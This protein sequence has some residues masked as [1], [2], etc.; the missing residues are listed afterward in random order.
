MIPKFL[1]LALRVFKRQVPSN[2][3]VHVLLY[4]L[5]DFP[6]EPRSLGL[7]EGSET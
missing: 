7:T 3:W 1:S 5:R 6:R 4:S 2:Q